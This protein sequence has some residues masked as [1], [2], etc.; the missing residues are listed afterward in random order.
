MTIKKSFFIINILLFLIPA[1]TGLYFYDQHKKT[2]ENYISYV[3]EIKTSIS[4]FDR[5]N[6]YKFRE[7]LEDNIHYAYI[8]HKK[9]ILYSSE[10][11]H[12]YGEMEKILRDR[13]YTTH[14]FYT[15]GGFLHLYTQDRNLRL[16]RPRKRE[17]LWDVITRPLYHSVLTVA[18]VSFIAYL[19]LRNLKKSIYN[20]EHASRKISDGDLSFT[21]EKNTI[22]ELE[23]LYRSLE[24]LK[25]ELRDARDKKA[26]FIM[27]V[28]HDLKT[29][30]ALIN[31]YVEALSDKLYTNDEEKESYLQIIK[32]KSSELE[33]IICDLIDLS[34]LDTGE[35][36]THLKKDEL[37]ELLDRTAKKYTTD[38][39]FLGVR[40]IYDRS[41]SLEIPFDQKLISRVLDNLFSNGVKAVEEK[42]LITMNFYRKKEHCV[43]EFK[44]NG[45]GIKKEDLTMIFEPFYK[46][47]KSRTDEGHGLGLATVKTILDNHGWKISVESEEGKGTAFSISIPL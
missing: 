5:E 4:E 23:P 30:L 40:F 2:R 18:A 21:M 45:R 1:V 33:G 47:S 20:L 29:P 10:G 16:P 26:R 46:G 41:T 27:G 17:T 19:M 38:A 35:W 28:S 24:S 8:N 14:F 31:G 43:L 32:E 22:K 11:I 7:L 6:P 9:E 39:G 42:G 15:E 12:N 44:D 34:R 37:S 13:N 25:T 36:R 3:K